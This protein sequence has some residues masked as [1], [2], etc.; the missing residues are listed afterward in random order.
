MWNVDVLQI[1]LL[2]IFFQL[3]MYY[4]KIH[5]DFSS[6][7][8]VIGIPEINY[9]ALY[10]L[11]LIYLPSCLYQ[12]FTILFPLSFNHILLVIHLHTCTH[13]CAQPLTSIYKLIYTFIY[14]VTPAQ[15]H[16]YIVICS[17]LY[18]H[19]PITHTHPHTH[20]HTHNIFNNAYPFTH[21]HLL[22]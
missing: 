20:I 7:V 16:P 12:L 13:V 17:H 3:Y 14:T 10:N 15:S 22:T 2:K 18:T 9:N 19:T 21:L 11:F 8:G 5:K 4:K 1:L 6:A